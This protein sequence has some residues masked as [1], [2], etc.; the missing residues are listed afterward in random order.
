MNKFGMLANIPEFNILTVSEDDYLSKIMKIKKI[1][2]LGSYITD[3]SI[4][5]VKENFASPDFQNIFSEL[6]ND[7]KYSEDDVIKFM[8]IFISAGI[9]TTSGFLASSL[10]FIDKIDKDLIH[11]DDYI[12]QFLNEVLRIHSPSQFTFRNTV[13]EVLIDGVLIPKDSLIAVSIGAANLDENKFKKASDFIINRN[14]KHI[15]FGIGNHKCIGEKLALNIGR[16]FLKH[17]Y[18]TYYEKG[19]ISFSTNVTNQN[20]IFFHK[21]D[22]LIMRYCKVS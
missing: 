20:S 18:N 8:T 21:I 10:Y 19:N 17:I 5:S 22:Q 9:L 11:Q 16:L 3:I 4:A 13:E 12:F 6:I 7:Q 15:S 14:I 1:Y 2:N